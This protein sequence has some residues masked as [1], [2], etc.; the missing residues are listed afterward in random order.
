MS[1]QSPEAMRLE[2]SAR[3]RAVVDYVL[4]TLTS[5]LSEM[6]AVGRLEQ[7]LP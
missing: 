6:G 3:G 4:R 7:G 1:E 5:R 2:Q